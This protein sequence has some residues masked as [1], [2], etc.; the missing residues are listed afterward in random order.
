MEHS[1]LPRHFPK[2]PLVGEHFVEMFLRRLVRILGGKRSKRRDIPGKIGA[3]PALHKLGVGP[4][5]RGPA[6][7]ADQRR[8]PLLPR[9]HRVGSTETSYPPFDLASKL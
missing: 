2:V 1:A 6:G 3:R 5:G 4:R 8:K 7:A 9:N